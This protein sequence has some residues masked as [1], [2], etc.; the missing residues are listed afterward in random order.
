MYNRQVGAGTQRGGKMWLKNP[1]TKLFG[2][3]T[4]PRFK[5]ECECKFC[6]RGD[7]CGRRPVCEFPNWDDINPL[8]RKETHER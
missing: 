1:W 5:C 7:H 4:L 2:G 8:L 3:K 6:D